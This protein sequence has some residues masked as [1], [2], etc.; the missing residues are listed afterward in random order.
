MVTSAQKLNRELAAKSVNEE[1]ARQKAIQKPH[2]D[3]IWNE[4][5]VRMKGLSMRFYYKVNGLKPS[6]G[7]SLYISMHGGGNAPASIND[8]QW[9]NQ[10]ALYDPK[11]GVYVA[12]RAPTN[13]WNLWHEDHMDDMLIE[14]IKAAIVNEE[15]NP[16]KVYIM[17]YSAGGDGVFQLAPRMADHWAAAAM[18]AGHP[19][20]AS[21]LG[22]RNL[23]FSI[24]MGG[25]DEA[26][27]RNGQAKIWANMLDSLENT[28]KNGYRHNLNIY[29][30][31]GHWMERKDSVAVPWMAGY[32]RSAVPSKV[33]WVQDDRLHNQFYWLAVPIE[34]AKPALQT[35][36]SIV[37]N[38]ITLERNDNK[39][40]YIYL[41]DQMLNLDKK[42]KLVL[43]G[44]IIFNQRVDR[45][46]QCIKSSAINLDRALIFSARISVKDGK[47]IL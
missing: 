40:L 35:I 3:S 28:D 16:D 41:N 42:V 31:M 26:Y 6:D 36:A 15:V 39:T 30:G 1:L 37:E 21:P 23:P 18:M 44:K 34:E 5:K 33:V 45:N 43:N 11:E 4:Q 7:R 9:R 10:L 47:A 38:T 46:F 22:L 2:L 17:G 20:D 29:K 14:I 24:F 32:R 19:N 27:N 13:T 8:S 25:D 12:P